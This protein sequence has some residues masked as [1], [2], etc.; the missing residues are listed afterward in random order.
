MDALIELRTLVA[1]LARRTPPAPGLPRLKWARATRPDVPVNVMA[2]ATLA[3]VVQGA[4]RTVVGARALDTGTGDMVITS[5]DTP[6]TTQVTRATAREPYLGVGLEI[7]PTVVASLLLDHAEPRRRTSS[8]AEPRSRGTPLAIAST[9]APEDLL[10]AFRRYLR[11][12]DEPQDIPVL[13][14]A[15]E[16]EILWRAMQSPQGVALRDTG[17]ASSNLMLVRRA[18]AVL[19]ERFVEP[20]QIPELARAAHMSLAS[21][22]RHFRKVTA[23][24]PLQFQKRLRLQEAR[25]RLLADAVDVTSVS[26]AVGYRSPSQF[27]REYRREFGLPPAEEAARWRAR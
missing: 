12:L 17:I 2:Q 1:R 22:H 10:D 3:V 20:L 15:I 9:R 18:I 11:L 16:R 25:S 27:S 8:A 21:F 6:V 19:Q 5:I 24:S 23:M 4:K 26:L 7:R 13:G 14:E